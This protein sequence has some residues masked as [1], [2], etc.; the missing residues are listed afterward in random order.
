MHQG[1]GVTTPVQHWAKPCNVEG[2]G[3]HYYD[4]WNGPHC[5]LSS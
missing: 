2:G 4:A 3:Y 5:P 1:I